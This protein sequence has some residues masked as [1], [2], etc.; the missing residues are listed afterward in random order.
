MKQFANKSDVFVKRV[1][2]FHCETNLGF[3]LR[4]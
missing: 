1:W 3:Y 4:D 2:G